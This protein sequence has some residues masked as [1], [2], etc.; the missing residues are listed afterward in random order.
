[1]SRLKKR[2]MLQVAIKPTGN[3]AGTAT[4]TSAQDLTFQRSFP[5]QG[6]DDDIVV[7]S[8]RAYIAALNK[9]RAFLIDK[10]VILVQKHSGEGSIGSEAAGEGRRRNSVDVLE[11]SAAS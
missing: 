6:A 9:M 5:G 7:A 4:V 1:M 10:G 3:V 11:P 8:T 2:C